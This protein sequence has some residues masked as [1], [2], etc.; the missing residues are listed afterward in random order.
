MKPRLLWLILALSSIW[1]AV[2]LI[3]ILAPNSASGYGEWRET[4]PIAA[5]TTWFFG[6]IATSAL[7]RDMVKSRVSKQVYMGVTIITIIIWLAAIPVSI[8][9]PTLESGTDPSIFPL[10]AIIAPLV[11]AVVTGLSGTLMRLVKEVDWS[12]DD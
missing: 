11:A 2:I 12:D 10:A 5:V 3:S 1:I 4:F 9:T 7:I 8:L 6:V